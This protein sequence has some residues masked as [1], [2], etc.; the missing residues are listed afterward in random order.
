MYYLIHSQEVL[1]GYLQVD[2]FKNLTCKIGDELEI[3]NCK[4][5]VIH[6]DQFEFHREAISKLLKYRTDYC[7]LNCDVGNYIP[8]SERN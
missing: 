8:R 7:K 6:I 1:E 4:S 5:T 3:A 2:L